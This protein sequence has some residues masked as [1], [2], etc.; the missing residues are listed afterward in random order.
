MSNKLIISD[1]YKNIL[2]GFY[3]EDDK[4]QRLV[5]LKNDNVVGNIY[6]GYVKD[7]VKNI[8][9]AFVLFDDNKKGYLS[10]KDFKNPVKQGD[11][12]LVQVSGDK[13]KT[14]DYS[15]TSRINLNSECLVLT[16]GNTGISVSR[17]IKDK[18]IR[19]ELKST[20]S[21]KKNDVY[22]F[23][24]RTNA[25]DFS[26]EDILKQADDLINQL[27]D[28]KKRFAFVTPKAALLKKD[29]LQDLISELKKHGELSII[30]DVVY[31]YDT[32]KEHNDM[33]TYNDNS[34]I[35]LC[36]K[37]SLETHL[38]RLLSKK[39]WLKSG[40]YLIIDETE[41]MT[42]ID[43]NSGKAVSQESFIKTNKE[44]AEEVARQIRLRNISGMIIVDFI[45][46]KGENDAQNLSN[47]LRNY[48]SKDRVK[49]RII[50]MTEL[51]LMQLT[52]QKIR[53]PLSKYILC[54]CPYCKGS[55]K[56]FLPEMIAEK[57]K[58]EII[59]VFTNTI[60]NKVTVSSNATI[61]KNLKAIFSMSN[62]YKDNITFNTI[63]TSK[64][65]YYLIEKFKK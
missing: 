38:N 4:L 12:V 18:D 34:K 42:V 47:L 46:T 17:K 36:N 10:L 41:A 55:G 31:I 7:V 33:V 37:Y 61:I 15:L 54:E 19:E 21:V 58:T 64:A 60:Y 14:K 5:N 57:I 65:D 24:I 25:V 2:F 27:E 56:I 44:A 9:G 39:V 1:F 53:K 26:K 40:G 28:L 43:V 30:T 32:L 48:I 13:I 23:I 45:N 49:T 16:V 11:K 20:L 52:R 35:S 29:Y 8:N 22:G 59:N 63:E 62:N 50:G 3:F 51:G 6:C